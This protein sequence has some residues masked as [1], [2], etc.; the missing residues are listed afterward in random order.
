M[1]RI[2]L[3]DGKV[4]EGKIGPIL[5]HPN[6]L[7]VGIAVCPRVADKKVVALAHAVALPL[8]GPQGIGAPARLLNSEA[9]GLSRLAYLA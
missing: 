7:F 1:N 6:K 3:R 8:S 4:L 5:E 2:I 9:R